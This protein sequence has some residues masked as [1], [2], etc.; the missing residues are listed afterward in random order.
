MCSPL[1]SK[2][3]IISLIINFKV[4]NLMLKYNDHYAV[5]IKHI[6]RI[7]AIIYKNKHNQE[8]R[9]WKKNH[10]NHLYILKGVDGT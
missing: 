4:L 9:P 10:L 1:C 2:S 5:L 7:Q 8:V 3:K 6:P